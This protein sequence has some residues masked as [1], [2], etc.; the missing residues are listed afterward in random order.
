MRW[1]CV[2]SARWRCWASAP[3]KLPPPMTMTSNGRASLCGLPFG[4]EA[5]LSV[6]CNASSRPLQMKRPRTS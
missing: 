4:R 6:L 1:L 2:L 5:F 3:P